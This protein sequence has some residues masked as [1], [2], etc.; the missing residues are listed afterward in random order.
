MTA[1]VL[2]CLVI[3]VR[4]MP[5]P[6]GAR[7]PEAGV[8]E[9]AR[10]PEV[11]AP[12]ATEKVVAPATEEEPR[13]ARE[14]PTG[15]RVNTPDS[16]L[17]LP[18]RLNEISGLSATKDPESLWAVHDE[19]GTLFRLSVKDGTVLEEVSLGKRGDYEAVEAVGDQVFVARSEGVLLVVDPT[20]KNEMVKLSFQK[21]I[22]LACDLEGLGHEPKKNRLLLTCKNESSKSRKSNKA[23]EIYAMDLETRTVQRDPA[24]VLNEPAI[25]EYIAA[26][27]ERED[28]KQSKGKEFA[29]SG[30]S[31]NP[32]TDEI[33]VL[34]TRG[35][36]IVV[37]DPKGALVRVYGLDPAVHPQPEGLTFGADGT[38][39]IGTEAH[40]KRAL[41]HAV[42]FAP[43]AASAS[44]ND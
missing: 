19:R 17:V 20:A 27:P 8:P 31:V 34:S 6:A 28:L 5:E 18:M 26:H 42:K 23:F 35:K 7:T 10:E 21:E 41:L 44:A 3:G 25:D 38:M 40:G 43:T 1:V 15:Y 9:I 11:V 33:Y 22:G 36:M 12:Q 32:K 29:P 14:Q 30:I 4:L 2:V 37:L 13:P 39:F 24:Y 16:T